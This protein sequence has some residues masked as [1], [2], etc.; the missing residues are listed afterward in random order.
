MDGNILSDEES[1][2]EWEGLR[3]K[4]IQAI[5]VLAGELAQYGLDART[6]VA[7]LETVAEGLRD[8]FGDNAK[9]AEVVRR[10]LATANQID[11][12][13]ATE[14]SPSGVAGESLVTQVLTE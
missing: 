7:P 8:Y 3:S 4:L 2:R 5:E 13:I 12:L 6:L 9:Q 14:I 10:G 1:A 11:R